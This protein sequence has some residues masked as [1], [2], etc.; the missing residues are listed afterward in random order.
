[1]T[2]RM[3]L[4]V[5]AVIAMA[6]GPASMAETRKASREDAPRRLGR[7]L[8]SGTANAETI[9]SVVL[10]V[11]EEEPEKVAAG[12]AT[13]LQTAIDESPAG[14][15]DPRGGAAARAAVD[16]FVTLLDD[17][18]AHRR[19]DA[20]SIA[21]DLAPLASAACPAVSEALAEALRRP[22]PPPPR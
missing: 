20:A 15:K 8:A 9:T 13:A 16:L 6:S 18:Q 7:A 10:W 21:R 22:P 19:R 4:A 14:T 2:R 11:L 1:M 12:L 5:T 17:A 3:V